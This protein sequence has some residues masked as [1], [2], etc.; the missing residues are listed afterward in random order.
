M[1]LK[2]DVII[3]PI[4]KGEDKLR[5]IQEFP[6]DPQVDPWMSQNLNVGSKFLSHSSAGN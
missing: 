4:S 2:T 1:Y 5:Q 3:I 6:Q